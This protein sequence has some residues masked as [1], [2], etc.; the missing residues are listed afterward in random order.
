V[1]EVGQQYHLLLEVVVDR[2]HSMEIPFFLLVEIILEQMVPL[3]LPSLHYL[4]VLVEVVA[5]QEHQL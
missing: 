5:V 4:M 3:V 2:L 1:V